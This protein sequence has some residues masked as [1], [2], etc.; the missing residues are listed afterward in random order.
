MRINRSNRSGHAWL[1]LL[2]AV[3][4]LALVLQLVPALGERF[5]RALDVRHWP[6]GIW[7]AVNAGAILALLW[8]RHGPELRAHRLAARLRRIRPA[9]SGRITGKDDASYDVRVKRDAEWRERAKKRL[10][11]V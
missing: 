2:L 1:E 4:L 10:P 9:T 8:F 3:S 11:F 5:I 6:R 7:L